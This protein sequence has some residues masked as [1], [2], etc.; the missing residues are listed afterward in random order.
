[1][2]SISF[3]KWQ[4]Q[5]S[6][7]QEIE[8]QPLEQAGGSGTATWAALRLLSPRGKV[9]PPLLQH[10]DGKAPALQGQLRCSCRI[11][12][13]TLCSVPSRMLSPDNLGT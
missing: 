12:Q 11:P 4:Q 2:R 6:F 13:Q 5:L 9:D 7:L 1:M 3:G 10:Y 8:S